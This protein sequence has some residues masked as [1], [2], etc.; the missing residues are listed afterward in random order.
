MG[1][2][3]VDFYITQVGAQAGT[4]TPFT[5]TTKIEGESDYGEGFVKMSLDGNE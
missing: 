3:M 2:K 1:I 5:A 4:G